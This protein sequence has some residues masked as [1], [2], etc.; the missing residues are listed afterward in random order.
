MAKKKVKK[1][2]VTEEFYTDIL[3]EYFKDEE[4]NQKIKKTYMDGDKFVREE[5]IN[6]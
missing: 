6:A 4:G 1:V 3:Q 5:V 2:V